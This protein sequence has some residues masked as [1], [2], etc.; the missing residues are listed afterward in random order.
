MS[1][2]ADTLRVLVHVLDGRRV[3]WFVFGAQAIDKSE[4]AERIGRLGTER[5]ADI[6]RGIRLVLDPARG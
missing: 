4:L 3:R 1:A 2:V 6:L 5:M